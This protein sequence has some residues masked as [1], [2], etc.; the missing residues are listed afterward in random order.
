MENFDY[1]ET[2][3]NAS[4]FNERILVWLMYL[5]YKQRFFASRLAS[6]IASAG[7]YFLALEQN[8]VSHTL[9]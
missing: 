6:F 1:T 3:N 7:E 5:I 9:K 4:E 2:S 8:T